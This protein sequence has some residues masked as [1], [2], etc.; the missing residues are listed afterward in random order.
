MY[1]L[2]AA[3]PVSALIVTG[4]YSAVPVI[5]PIGQVNAVHAAVGMNRCN[6]PVPSVTTILDAENGE[7]LIAPLEEINIS[8]LPR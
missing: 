3:L 4:E 5:S 1:A 7:P 6:D 2:A 8:K